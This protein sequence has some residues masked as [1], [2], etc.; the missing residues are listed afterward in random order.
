MA[1]QGGDRSLLRRINLLATLR[2]AH[3]GP[4]TIAALAAATSL[5]RTAAESVV[6]DLV[7]LGWLTEDGQSGQSGQSRHSGH[8]GVGRPARHYRLRAEAGA[9]LGIDVGP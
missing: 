4:T 2:S 9:L 6:L 3:G 7:E 8:S 5:S 1:T